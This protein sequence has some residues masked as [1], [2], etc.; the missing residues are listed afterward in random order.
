MA[1][2]F[3]RS[4]AQNE[5]PGLQRVEWRLIEAPR[6]TSVRARS[7]FPGVF[8]ASS[9]QTARG[10]A[11]IG[12]E[13]RIRVDVDYAEGGE[14]LGALARTIARPSAS[15]AGAGKTVGGGG[16][17]VAIA[18]PADGA[19]ALPSIVKATAQ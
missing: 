6:T 1:V 10:V 5:T 11:R 18:P 2:S 3:E 16:G 15:A 17:T 9:C 12:T 13:G 19:R 7:R 4:N 14:V 8:L